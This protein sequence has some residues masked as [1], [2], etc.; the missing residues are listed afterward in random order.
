MGDVSAALRSGNV[1]ERYL[2]GTSGQKMARAQ[3]EGLAGA[4]MCVGGAKTRKMK[5][6]GKAKGTDG[7]SARAQ[8]VKA[9]MAMHG[10]SMCA[11]SKYLK[12]NPC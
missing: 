9:I 7:R 1:A 2:T 10:L 6:A 3:L 8:K 4:G 11:A 12:E 5:G